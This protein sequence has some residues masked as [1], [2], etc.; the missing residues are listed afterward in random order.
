MPR[1]VRV[2]PCPMTAEPC[3]YKGPRASGRS[4]CPWYAACLGEYTA[5]MLSA[6]KLRQHIDKNTKEDIHEDLG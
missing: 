5:L 1:H 2:K 3:I 4:Q 6:K